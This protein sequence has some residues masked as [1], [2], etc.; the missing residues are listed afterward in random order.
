M[1]ESGVN[2][3]LPMTIAGKLQLIADLLDPRDEDG[4]P[5]EPFLTKEEVAELLEIEIK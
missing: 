2:N 3:P 4:N 1:L 5:I